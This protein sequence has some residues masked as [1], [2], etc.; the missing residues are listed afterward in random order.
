[1]HPTRRAAIQHTL[2]QVAS[3]DATVQQAATQSLS[4]FVGQ[5]NA[6]QLGAAVRGHSAEAVT[7]AMDRISEVV[8]TYQSRA[9]SDADIL[10]AFQTGEAIASVRATAATPLTDSQLAAVAD[11]VL[12]PSRQL[13]RRDLVAVIADQAG[14]E[15]STDQS[16]AAAI[17]S[18]VGFGGQTGNVRGILNAARALQLSSQELAA[19]TDQVSQGM[20][21]TAA[22]ELV[23]RGAHPAVA[24]GLVADIAALPAHFAV[25]QSSAAASEGD[26]H[27]A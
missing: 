2:Q 4:N 11:T 23:G 24:R 15:T 25:P 18:P 26:I 21:R 3:G 19:L 6:H 16:V 13:S 7:A 8:T 9:V 10:H 17:G 5:A 14:A 22:L 1:M 20:R 27:D 12:L